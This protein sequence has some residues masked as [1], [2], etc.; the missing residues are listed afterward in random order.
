MVNKFFLDREDTVLIIIDFQEKLS[1]K[2][3]YGKEV[4]HNIKVIVETCKILNIPVILTEQYPRGIGPTEK[5]ITGILPEHKPV[6]KMSF[7]CYRE[8]NFVTELEKLKKKSVI[9]TG[10]EAHICVLQTTLDCMKAGYYVHVL[11]D[12]VSSRTKFNWETGLKLMR[13]A[14]VVISSTEIAVF[15][16]L[17]ESG[18]EEFKKIHP[19]IK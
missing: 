11:R 10:I 1:A 12:C 17:K 15:Q 6:T 8:N 16:L 13:D 5:D 18:T 2:M 9:I 3:K 14:G 4:L 7:S 19:F